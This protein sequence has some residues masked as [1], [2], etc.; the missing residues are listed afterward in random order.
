MIENAMASGDQR[1]GDDEARENVAAD[2]A[3]PLRR[4]AVER[5]HEEI[6]VLSGEG[7]VR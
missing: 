1:E 6:G 5:D 4:I 7:M 2:V 3:G